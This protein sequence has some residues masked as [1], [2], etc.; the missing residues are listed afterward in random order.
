MNNPHVR[1]AAY[2]QANQ[3]FSV[4]RQGAS[5]AV[6]ELRKYVQEGPAGVSILC[7]LGGLATTIVGILGLLNISSSLTSPFQYVLNAYLTLFGV[8]TVLL[9]AD[10][11]SFGRM[12]VLGK[13]K[14]FVEKYQMEVFNRAKVLTELRGRGFYYVFLG[15]L[16]VTQCMFCLDFVIGLWNVLMGALC[17]MMSFG[18]N[19]ANHMNP[20]QDQSI[21]LHTAPYNP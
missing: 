3:G 8:V 13:L 10:M 16:A 21:P 9:E 17:L 5:Q 14:P 20:N 6:S 19:P 12:K 2:E 4:V 18:I 11:E 15:S 7:F 1:D